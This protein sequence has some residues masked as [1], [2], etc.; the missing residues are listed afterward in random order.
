M[1]RFFNGTV[2]A[3]IEMQNWN[4]NGYEPDWSADFLQN[5]L[6]SYDDES[7]TYIVDDITDV[8]KTAVDYASRSGEYAYDPADENESVSVRVGHSLDNLYSI[9][10]AEHMAFD[11]QG[12]HATGREVLGYSAAGTITW[13]TEYVGDDT[14]DLPLT[15]WVDWDRE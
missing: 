6:G 14:E 3:E 1:T 11:S 9:R 10:N 5:Y 4:G 15:E 7:D 12:R 13:L 2:Y 8:C